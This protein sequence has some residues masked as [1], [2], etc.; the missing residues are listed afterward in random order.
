MQ[1]RSREQ[2][3]A[4]NS[5]AYN[6]GGLGM[7]GSQTAAHWHSIMSRPRSN[8]ACGGMGPHPGLLRSLH[9]AFIFIIDPKPKPNQ[10]PHAAACG[11]TSGCCAACM[12]GICVKVRAYRG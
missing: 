4:Y 5:M 1:R 12:H 2:G 11:R 9:P 10:A 8:A 6:R 7:P 3:V